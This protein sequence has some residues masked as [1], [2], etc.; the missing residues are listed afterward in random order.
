MLRKRTVY[1]SYNLRPFD[2]GRFKVAGYKQQAWIL[3]QT[4]MDI[5]TIAVF[6]EH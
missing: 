6:T 2:C 4:H 1:F 3:S 5:V